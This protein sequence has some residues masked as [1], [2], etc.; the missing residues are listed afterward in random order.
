MPLKRLTPEMVEILLEGRFIA[1]DPSSCSGSSALGW[2]F[3]NKGELV[4]S[5]SV[6]RDSGDSDVYLRLRTVTRHLHAIACSFKP[7]MLVLEQLRSRCHT[8]LR[9]ACGVT[10]VCFGGPVLEITPQHWRRSAPARHLADKKAGAATDQQDAQEIGFTAVREALAART[11]GS[12][13]S[14]VESKGR[15]TR[16][17]RKSRVSVRC[18][19]VSK[20]TSRKVGK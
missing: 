19:R 6:H 16:V 3:F 13:S 2:A 7:G 5:G 4:T 20:R 9:W 8:Y 14:K 18:S 12:V 11:A 1:V 15:S 17:K 10:I